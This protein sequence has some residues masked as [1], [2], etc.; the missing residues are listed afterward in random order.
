MHTTITVLLAVLAVQHTIA[1]TEIHGT[2]QD[3]L[4]E[5][6]LSNASVAVVNTIDSSVVRGVFTNAKGEFI[7]T[8]DDPAT[9]VVRVH[10]VGYSTNFQS[11]RLDSNVLAHAVTISLYP[12]TAESI[13]VTANRDLV[14]Y[15]ANKIVLNVDQSLAAASTSAADILNQ[16]PTVQVDQEGT[17]TVK[18]SASVNVQIDGKPIT[19]YG[20]PSDVLKNIPARMLDRVELTTNPGAQHDAQGQYGILNII[21]KKQNANGINGLISSSAGVFDSYSISGTGNSRADNFNVFINAD[22]TSNRSIRKLESNTLFNDGITLARFGKQ[23]ARGLSTGISGGVDITFSTDRT[24]TLSADFRRYSSRSTAPFYTTTTAGMV[25]PASTYSAYVPGVENSFSSGGL[26]IDYVEKFAAKGSLLRGKCFVA[27]D[28]FDITSQIAISQ[29]DSLF[30]IGESP[31]ENRQSRMFGSGL[32]TQLQLDYELPLTDEWKLET[33]VK[34]QTQGIVGTYLFERQD[35]AGE[36][37]SDPDV[38]NHAIHQDNVYA[39]YGNVGLQTK[40]LSLQGGLR[41]ELTSNSFV[42]EAEPTNNIHRKFVGLFPSISAS[43]NVTPATSLAMS[44]SRRINRPH[45]TQIN[46]FID[47]SDTL[48]WRTGNPQ[49]LPEYTH[50]LEAGVT[51]DFGTTV[52]TGGAFL[53]STSNAINLRYRERVINNVILEKPYN[54]GNAIAYGLNAYANAS[55]ASLL[56]ISGEL[57]YFYQSSKGNF[58]GSSYSSSSYGWNARIITSLTIPDILSAQVYFDYAAPQ[59][60]PQGRRTAFNI[61]SLGVSKSLLEESLQI[62][63]NWTDCLRTAKFGGTLLTNSFSADMLNQRDYELF[64]LNVSYKLNNYKGRIPNSNQPGGGGNSNTI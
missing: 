46:P 22:A 31:S 63:F 52:L 7:V 29:T 20:S 23:Y 58:K 60:I 28:Q 61:L 19:L 40:E 30:T 15:S 48:N 62:G 38:S 10:Y 6:R 26:Y 16:V 54:F 12:K 33:G 3:A 55:V 2:V 64:S 14:E 18:G 39:A 53:R 56:R 21:L 32:T 36:F 11:L 5:Q 27:P 35:I 4:T 25:N 45:P 47:K 51:Q 44:Y 17:L 34:V 37:I 50:A 24:L 9:Q 43:V 13:T 59:V 8:V 49:L 57:S 1:S 41:T 42:N